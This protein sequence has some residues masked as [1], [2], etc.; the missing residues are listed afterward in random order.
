MSSGIGI[1]KDPNPLSTAKAFC[2]PPARLTE[3][4]LWWQAAFDPLLPWSM[5]Y[6]HSLWQGCIRPIENIG[7]IHTFK[8]VVSR[9][10]GLESTPRPTALMAWGTSC[11]TQLVFPQHCPTDHNWKVPV[12]FMCFPQRCKK[13]RCLAGI[14]EYLLAGITIMAHFWIPGDR[15]FFTA[16]LS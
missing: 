15:R 12:K 7:D 1:Q 11:V 13:G 16:I 9:K 6:G 8:R 5:T 14:H 4:W 2:F 10:H 3:C